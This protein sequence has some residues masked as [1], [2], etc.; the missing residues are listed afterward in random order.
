[1][2]TLL[3]HRVT[4]RGCRMATLITNVN[5]VLVAAFVLGQALRIEADFLT[6]WT[7][8]LRLFF[9]HQELVAHQFVMRAERRFATVT[10]VCQL[11][12]YWWPLIG[13][14]HVALVSHSILFEHENFLAHVARVE[15]FEN[16]VGVNRFEVFVQIDKG[17]KT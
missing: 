16:L 11:I 14:F 6:N 10:F 5:V 9:A 13:H 2:F 4:H 12:R 8:E 17:D 15:L 7:N 3:V 1:M